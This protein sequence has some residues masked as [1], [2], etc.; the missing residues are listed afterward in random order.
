LAEAIVTAYPI[1]LSFDATA[2]AISSVPPILDPCA[3]NTFIEITTSSIVKTS[4]R[5]FRSL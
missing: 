2:Y 4:S 1:V 5:Q 3:T